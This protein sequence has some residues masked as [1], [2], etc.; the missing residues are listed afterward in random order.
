MP[1]SSSRHASCMLSCFS[2]VLLFVTL[3]TV[4]CQAPL[5]MGFSRP[6][7]WSGLPCYPPG[8]LPVTG[9][10]PMSLMSPA[11]AGG[12]FTTSTTC[13]ALSRHLGILIPLPT[14]PSPNGKSVPK[15]QSIS[16]LWDQVLPPNTFCK[17]R[18]SHISRMKEN[19]SLFSFLLRNKMYADCMQLKAHGSHLYSVGC[20]N[21]NGYRYEWWQMGALVVEV[22]LSIEILFQR[23]K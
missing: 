19:K 13:E 14:P 22:V 16:R 4:A 1:V 10:E 11:L 12:F 9:I 8:D 6:E 5:S 2:C 7:H 17:W 15:E 18:T 23:L 20:G 3:W 21:L